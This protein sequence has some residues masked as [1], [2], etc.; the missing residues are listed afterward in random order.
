MSADYDLSFYEK[1]ANKNVMYAI[2]TA[3]SD[4]R[5]GH[6]LWIRKKSIS[7]AAS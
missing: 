1:S 6:K 4:F 7:D 5:R 2:I 3:L